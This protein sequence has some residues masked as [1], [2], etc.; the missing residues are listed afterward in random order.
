MRIKQN[1]NAADGERGSHSAEE[2]A[3]ALL[4]DF[5]RGRGKDRGTRPERTTPGHAGRLGEDTTVRQRKQESRRVAELERELA[6]T[7]DYLQ[8][9][10]EQHE[11]AN[12]ELQASNEEV[13]SA[14]EELQSINEEL[15]TSKEELESANEEL[16]TVNEE[17]ANRNTEL[18]R[19]NSDLINLQTSTKLAIVLL[20]R[21]LTIRRFSP[22]AEKHFNL[23]A[24]DVG[25]PCQRASGTISTL[26]RLGERSL[27]EVI[28]TVREQRARS[29]GQG[30][31]AGIRCACAPT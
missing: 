9:I 12:E 17:M 28:D 3:G 21:D 30:R 31:A 25:R 1:G 20:G 18:N 24:T 19:L 29:A 6:E 7:R 10:Q 15:E 16:T 14:N 11:A 27:R 13:Q 4:F 26:P 2:S 5:V 22:Q 8:S 23:L